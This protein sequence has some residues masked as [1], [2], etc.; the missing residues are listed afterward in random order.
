MSTLNW[1]TAAALELTDELIPDPDDE[2]RLLRSLQA[3]RV[4]IEGSF[5]HV[6][7]RQPS[8]VKQQRSRTSYVITVVPAAAVRYLRYQETYDRN[9]SL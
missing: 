5:V 8:A 7:P 2:G 4:A 3:V 9:F 1:R 6:D